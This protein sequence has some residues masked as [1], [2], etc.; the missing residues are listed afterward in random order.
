MSS[1]SGQDIIFFPQPLPHSWDNV[2]LPVDKPKGWSSFYVIKKLRRLLNIKKIG[3]AGTLDPMATGLLIC[4]V[5]RA[6]KSMTYY[7]EMEKTY[8]GTI[9]L[10]ENTPS[11]DAETEVV[12]RFPWE[13]IRREDLDNARLKFTGQIEQRPPMFSAVKVGGER[14]YKKARRGE[15]VERKFRT[16]NVYA[17]DLT[18]ISGQDVSFRIRCSKGTYIRSLAYDFGKELGTGAHLISLRRA[19]IG[20]IN[21]S[22][23]WSMDELKRRLE[24]PQ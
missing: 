15:E 17:F 24:S 8:V 9:R 11:Y 12:E 4:L 1:L 19:A 23:A 16:V 21:V 20:E 18:D 13:H 3:H 7:Q 6:T 2:V 5:G 10:G 22:D 14:L